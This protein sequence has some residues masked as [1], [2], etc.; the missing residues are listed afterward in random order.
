MLFNVTPK[1]SLFTFDDCDRHKKYLT[2]SCVQVTAV[3]HAA[4]L[5]AIQKYVPALVRLSIRSMYEIMTRTGSCN[6]MCVKLERSIEK[7]IHIL[8]VQY[9]A[10]MV[11]GVEIL[12]S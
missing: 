5:A 8:Y 9:I 10:V 2:F 1:T 4:I 12:F 11:L 7:H 3:G 6:A